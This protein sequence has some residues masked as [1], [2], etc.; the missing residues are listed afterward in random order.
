MRIALVFLLSLAISFSSFSQTRL[1]GK[2][3]AQFSGNQFL[4]I[5]HGEEVFDLF[6]ERYDFVNSDT[7]PGPKTLSIYYISSKGK[8]HTSKTFWL[9]EGEY[10]LTG[11]VN[12]PESWRL[13]PEHPFTALQSEI[14]TAESEIKKQLITKNLDKLVGIRMLNSYKQIFSDEELMGL[15]SDIPAEFKESWE[16]DEVKTYL[17]LNTLARAQIGELAPDFTLES[18]AGSDF[19]LSNQKGKYVLLDFSFTGCAGCVKAL[20]ELIELQAELS[21]QV[22]FVTVWNDRTRRTWLEIQKEHKSQMNWTSLWDRN[23]LATKLFEIEI[24]PSFVLI[25]PEGEVQS[26]WNGYSK[27]KLRRKLGREI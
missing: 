2:L 14:T 19:S 17:S 24:F 16:I 18:K 6:G 12:D 10:T 25:N 21:D 8:I 7:V 9:E 26:I 23:S 4:R 1:I 5:Q 27:G 3:E 11:K 22:E 13:S 15:I 20:P